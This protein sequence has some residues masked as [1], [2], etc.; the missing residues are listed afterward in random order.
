M[1]RLS[2]LVAACVLLAGASPARAASSAALA[3]RL[4]AAVAAGAPGI[5]ALSRDGPRTVQ[6]AA[7][8]GDR[9]R[10]T[11]MRT[12]DRFRIGSVTKTFVATLVLQLAGERRLSLDDTVE[13][14]LPGLV[15]GGKAITVRE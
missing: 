13:R 2:G 15:P 5:I 7:G 10:Q 9:A 1:R 8:V 4:R 12:G 6:L 3:G 11:P 14:W